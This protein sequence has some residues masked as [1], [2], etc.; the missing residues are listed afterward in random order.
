MFFYI[1]LHF[2]KIALIQISHNIKLKYN[3][4]N[5]LIGGNPDSKIYT[6]LRDFTLAIAPSISGNF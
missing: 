6:L 5:P 2:H 4:V 3:P 1:H